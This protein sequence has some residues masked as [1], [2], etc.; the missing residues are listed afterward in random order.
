MLPAHVVPQRSRVLE[1]LVWAD[2]TGRLW[3]PGPVLVLDMSLEVVSILEHLVTVRTLDRLARLAGA[4]VH[5][6]VDG[7]LGRAVVVATVPVLIELVVVVRLLE[8]VVTVVDGREVHLLRGVLRLRL[9]PV[10]V[11]MVVHVIT[12]CDEIPF[13]QRSDR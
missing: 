9:C 5:A 2:G 11:D 6:V 10:V 12:F 1:D 4:A 13:L 3:L 7:V 8:G